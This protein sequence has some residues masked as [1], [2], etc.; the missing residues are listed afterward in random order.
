MSGLQRLKR[1]LLPLIKGLPFVAVVFGLSLFLAH[2]IILYTPNTYQTIARIKLDDQ[3]YGFSNSTLYEDFDVFSTENKIEAE[4]EILK[5]PLIIEQALD[6]VDIDMV[7]YRVGKLKNTLLYKDNPI[8]IFKLE[9]RDEFYDRDYYLEAFA[10]DQ[11]L[12]SFS[13][14]DSTYSYRA[15]FED[16]VMLPFGKLCIGKNQDLLEQ[17]IDLKGKYVFRF[18]SRQKT[19]EH[20]TSKLDVTAI[21]K[22]VAVLRVVFK[23]EHPELVADFANALCAA[24]M[25]DYVYTKTR[26]ADQTMRF[27]DAKLDRIEEELR[28]AEIRLEQFKAVNGVVNTRQETETGLRQIS[29]LQVQL[30][31][32]EMNESAV[33]ELEAYVQSGDYFEETAIAFGFGDLLMTELVKKLKLYYDEREDLLVK[34]KPEHELVKAQ[35]IKIEE[36]KR[37]I[38][39]AI[40]QNKKEISTKRTEIETSLAMAE[41]Q[42]NG[43]STREKEQHRLERDFQL[44]ESVY[45]FLSQKKVEA[46]IASTALLS[47]HRIIQRAVVPSD[48]VSPNKTLITFV[49][50]FLG[51]LIS[52]SFIYLYRIARA[53]ISSR[54]DLERH[55][56][57]PIAAMIKRKD[58]GESIET[59]I[60]TL[61]LK[62]L[63]EKGSIICVTSTLRTEGVGFVTGNLVEQYRRMGKR[64]L[65]VDFNEQASVLTEE[66]E[67]HLSMLPEKLTLGRLSDEDLQ[68][69][70][71]NASERYDRIVFQAPPTAIDLFAV[72]LMKIS[73]ISLY[74]FRSG[75]TALSY[76]DHPDLLKEEYG[77]D[78]VHL[79]LNDV[80]RATSYSGMFVG[81]RFKRNP[82]SGGARIWQYYQTYMRS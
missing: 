47:F 34:Y 30:I 4:A 33:L 5:S 64:C 26:A 77:L 56:T 27:I 22:E 80:H 24:Y 41:Q 7:A 28:L 23:E 35:N 62:R 53:R 68:L 50:G 8:A 61:D 11:F 2:K 65:W 38:K 37:Y 29:D 20:V 71:T 13:W 31:N 60:R 75:V 58:N 39:E 78:N 16:S 9:A 57:L 3:K 44:K 18:R 14:R 52:I 48:P 6:S 55:S 67:N 82:S 79:I 45:N 19:V 72:S 76:V 40:K 17:G 70:L 74:V 21:D 54:E 81:T 46:S 1:Q 32:L 51:L 66:I 36:V 43:L 15:S 42:F 10:D 59:L 25:N 69:V 12:L 49:I 63:V 73:T